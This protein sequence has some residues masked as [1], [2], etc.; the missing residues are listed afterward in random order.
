LTL[1][2]WLDIV[3][4][5]AAVAVPVVVAAVGYH[6]N[7]QIKKWEANQW[8]NQELIKARLAYYKD[9][10]HS[11]N[12]VMCY[13]TFIGDWKG[14]TPEAIHRI[15]RDLDRMFYSA[16]P[17]FSPRVCEYYERFMESCFDTYSGWGR[18]ARLR[19]GFG[20]RRDAFGAA[21][22]PDWEIMFAYQEGQQIP[23]QE[24]TEI[25]TRY[26]DLMTALASDIELT[27][28]HERYAPFGA[29]LNAD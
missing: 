14:H 27:A 20:R 23:P 10:S 3:K 2:A 6:F 21:W 18:D 4:T 17:L 7:R 19:T 12:D 5:V 15:K 8:R 9:F 16:A 29:V 22:R 26:R 1:E 25:R 24:M 13:F 28:P 11:L